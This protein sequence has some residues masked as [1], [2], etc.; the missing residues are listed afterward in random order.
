MRMT[1]EALINMLLKEA[2]HIIIGCLEVGIGIRG[3]RDA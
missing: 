2:S 3:G 1:R